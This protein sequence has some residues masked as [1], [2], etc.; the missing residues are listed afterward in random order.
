MNSSK[1]KFFKLDLFII[2]KNDI[3]IKSND[4]DLQFRNNLKDLTNE[5][6]P[7]IETKFKS[8]LNKMNKEEF[9]NLLEEF[10]S[11]AR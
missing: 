2:D 1:V 4:T 11:I 8:Q 7:N 10:I 5:K 9:L 6:L 3:K